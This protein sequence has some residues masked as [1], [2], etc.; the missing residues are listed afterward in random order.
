[1]DKRHL[2]SFFAALSIV[3][4]IAS[5]APSTT[6]AP[7]TV[8]VE[9][10][11]QVT[12]PAPT[13][14][15]VEKVVQVTP[16]PK[17]VKLVVLTHWG[18]EFQLKPMQAKFQEYMKLNP[19]V[20]IEYQTVTF[21][22]LLTK[23]TTAR[24][25]GVSP[26]IYHFYNLWQPDFVKGGLLAVPPDNIVADVKASYSP[27]SIQSVTYANQIWGYPTE[28]NTYQLIYN[29]K[30]LKEAGFD[31]PPE[32]LDQLRDVA[33][34]TKQVDGSGKIT[35]SGLIVL[36]GWDSGVVHPYLSLLW[37]SGGDYISPD[38]KKALFN[39]PEGQATLGLYMDMIKN[40]CIDTSM[41]QNDFTSGKGAML[42]MFNS[43]R[44]Q[45]KSTFADGWDNVGVAP[46]PH[47]P[48]NTSVALQYNWAFGVDNGSKNREEAWKLLQ[49][50][51]T[52]SDTTKPSPIGDYLVQVL[53]AIPSRLND[54]KVL[55]QPLSEPFLKTY[56][57]SFAVARPEPVLPRGQ[58]VKT[59][60]Q[61]AIESAWFGK[62]DPNKALAGAAKEADRILAEK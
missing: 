46:I 25:A 44:G 53:G 42:I 45:L 51:D 27:V 7:A 59:L 26:D 21:D 55:A 49:W 61:N 39:S 32:T 38:G 15:V 24:A 13:A 47:G 34:K 10:V 31:K 19:H 16:T 37:S 57:D 11:V 12:V 33:C 41:G 2:F 60:L 40:K 6:P 1:M 18:E 36:P 22:Q 62:Q 28:I 14:A 48:N 4:L 54:Q 56:V 8:V 23:I 35:R 43:L 52:S 5:C 50:L 17:P 29:K 20:T 30:I 58:E 9:K 3:L